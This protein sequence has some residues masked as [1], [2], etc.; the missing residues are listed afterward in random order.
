MYYV[1]VNVFICIPNGSALYG[2]YAGQ[3]LHTMNRYVERLQGASNL[4]MVAR[5]TMRLR[6]FVA[7]RAK[8]T[9]AFA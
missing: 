5:K 1:A 4:V 8:M 3:R 9:G 2:Q 6:P 7:T